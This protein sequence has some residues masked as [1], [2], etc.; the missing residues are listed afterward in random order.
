[1]TSI[2]SI[3]PILT[4][5]LDYNPSLATRDIS[6]PYVWLNAGCDIEK[7]IL[8]IIKE[9]IKRRSPAKPKI[10]TFSYFTNAVLSARDRRLMPVL[11]K[12]EKTQDEQDALRAKN[13]RWHK[14][15]GLRTTK[16]GGQDFEWL[17]Q[18]ESK[19]GRVGA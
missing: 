18:Y 16:V 12:V 3:E 4:L 2:P 5:L 13:I 11:N 15:K 10:S 17:A 6:I 1:M 7:D 14:D 9:I 8:P 19:H